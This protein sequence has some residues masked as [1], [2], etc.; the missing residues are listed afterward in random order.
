MRRALVVAAAGAAVLAATFGCAAPFNEL[1]PSEPRGG[2]AVV[3]CGSAATSPESVLKAMEPPTGPTG[4][5]SMPED[6]ELRVC[7]RLENHG[8]DK[9]RFVR[10]DVSLRTPH[11]NT[12]PAA[13]SDDDL[14]IAL[15]GETRELHVS[16][17]YSPLVHGEDVEVILASALSVGGK[18]LKLPPIVLRKQ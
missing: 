8:S 9:A 11:E 5:S 1:K 7:L 18:P 2:V 16:F 10:S 13:D 14:V 4:E 12:Q 17:R 6:K 3:Y 15:P